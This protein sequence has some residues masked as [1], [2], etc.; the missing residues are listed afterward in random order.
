MIGRLPRRTI[1]GD[2]AVTVSLFACELLRASCTIVVTTPARPL[3]STA[4]NRVGHQLRVATSTNGAYLK[5]QPREQANK[6]QRESSLES[7]T[8]RRNNV[9]A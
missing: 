1:G 2:F 3:R 6:V 4:D 7:A 9:L 5:K 8:Q